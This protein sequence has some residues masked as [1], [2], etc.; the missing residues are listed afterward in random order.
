MSIHE[1]DIVQEKH[2]YAIIDEVD[3][4]LVDEARTP[5]II[6]GPTEES[7][8]KYF[9][10]DKLVYHLKEE[11]DYKINEKERTIFLTEKGVAKMEKLLSIDNLYSQNNM[12]LQHHIIQALRAHKLYKKDVD[13]VVK[14]GEVI[15]VDEFT[16]RLM[17]GRRYSDGLH[18]AIEAKENV[19][20]AKESQ[21]LATITFQNFFRLYKKI[22]GMT[23]TA[24]T[25]EDEFIEIYNL[26]VVV[27]PT[28]K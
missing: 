19:T 9:Q 24:K 5:L 27:I 26:P 7:T 3:S 1:A 25:E 12:V 22:A 14:D 4:I 23:G 28:N 16:G 11:D 15:I 6:S 17:F 2:D 10:I 13:Y 21:T 20:I 8:K 18:Q